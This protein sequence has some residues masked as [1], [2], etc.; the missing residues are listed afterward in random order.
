[1]RLLASLLLFAAQL[2]PHLAAA[3][4]LT[5]TCVELIADTDE[6]E[7]LRRLVID[8]MGRHPTH[9]VVEKNCPSHLRVELITFQGRRYLTGRI[10]AQVPHRQEIEG[11]NYTKG[12][13]DLLRVVLHHDPIRLR[14][15][16]HEGWL[17]SRLRVLKSGR[18]GVGV[19]FF[20]VGGRLEGELMSLPGVAVVG[21]REVGDWHLAG[22]IGFAMRV[23]PVERLSFI[24]QL[25]LQGQ[26][27]YYFSSGNVSPYV[28]GVFG[29]EDQRFRGPVHL[30]GEE[31]LDDYHKLG[32]SL[33]LRLG[34]E[35]FR[36]T[37]T[38]FDL[39][40]QGSAPLFT[41]T[42]EEA[43]V[44]DAYFPTLSFGGGF[45]F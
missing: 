36:L 21:R 33:G 25:S 3:Q 14:D 5:E 28:A 29:V 8:E 27:A 1:M 45:I 39:Y 16:R 15:P 13:E 43:Y 17:R 37:A 4:R 9:Q 12:I 38:R 32:L 42:D 10:N 18:T 23:E 34:L 41:A 22:R 7:A 6:V 44:I 40:L 11:D 26:A 31:G 24:Q 2:L 19:E 35:V 20:Q 30:A